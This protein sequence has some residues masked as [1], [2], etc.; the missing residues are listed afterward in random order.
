[1]SNTVENRQSIN[2]KGRLSVGLFLFEQFLWRS[3]SSHIQKTKPV[4]PRV[5]RNR[6]HRLSLIAR[7][8]LT[9]EEKFN[10]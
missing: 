1:L 5:A 9:R 10:D 7:A 2:L 8:M 4:E 6:T 3:R